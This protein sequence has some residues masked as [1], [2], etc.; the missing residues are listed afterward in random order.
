MLS[1]V[2][3]PN[4]YAGPGTGYEP[5]PERR[6]EIDAIRQQRGVADLRESQARLIPRRSPI[7]LIF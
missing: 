5:D 3:D 6:Q 2:T 4:D 7:G 1:L